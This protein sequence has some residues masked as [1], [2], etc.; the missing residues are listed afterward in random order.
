MS[1]SRVVF[2]VII[3]VALLVVI[4]VLVVLPALNI[5]VTGSSANCTATATAVSLT[6]IAVSANVA[7]TA[8]VQSALANTVTLRAIYGSEK[9]NWFKDAINRF[10]AANPG[11]AIDAFAE[12]SVAAYSDLSQ[13]T[14]TATVLN[15]NNDPIPAVWSPASQM[16]VNLVNTNSPLGHSVAIQCKSLVVSPLVI[17]SWADRAKAFADF[18]KDKGGITLA[19]LEDALDPQGKAKG[20]WANVGGSAQWGLVNFAHTDPTQSNSGLMTL[21]MIANNALQQAR[22]ITVADIT[23]DPFSTWLTVLEKANS[24][25]L[26]SQAASSTGFLVSDMIVK[27]PAQYDFVIAY[28]SLAIDN[29]KNALGRQG[30][31]LTIVYPQFD[32]QSDHPLCLIDHPQ[33]TAAQRAAAKK[34]QDFLLSA[35]IQRLALHY[36]FRPSDPTIALFGGNTAFDDPQLIAAGLGADVKNGGTVQAIQPPDG[37]TLQQLQIVWKRST[38][39]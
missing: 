7:A 33:I 10:E 29:F 37:P 12:G 16:E 8:T 38:G 28:E 26:G 39:A 6:N 19:N 35:D 20:K 31:G 24:V 1:R 4:G 32:V 34:F 3:G 9:E 18:Y 14:S 27:G 15:K 11:I 2:F 13:L 21:V 17:I 25:Q 30:Q 36:G 23:S 22:P 5:C